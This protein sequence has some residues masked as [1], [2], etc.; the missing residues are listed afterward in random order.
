MRL[1]RFI[2]PRQKQA[3]RIDSKGK[4]RDSPILTAKQK[5]YDFVSSLFTFDRVSS[6]HKGKNLTWTKDYK[7]RR[8]RREE[9][10]TNKENHRWK[11]NLSIF[12]NYH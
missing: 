7:K 4:N 9:K 2:Y 8:R 3:E 11:R 12:Y 1:E 5:T 6:G 10:K